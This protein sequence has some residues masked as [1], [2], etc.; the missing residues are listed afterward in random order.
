[1]DTRWHN[2]VRLYINGQSLIP[3]LRQPMTHLNNYVCR[4]F[5]DDANTKRPERRGESSTKRLSLKFVKSSVKS[6]FSPQPQIAS[7]CGIVSRYQTAL[8]HDLAQTWRQLGVLIW[9]V[10]GRVEN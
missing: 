3:S 6:V 2:N 5:S 8:A 7:Y 10:L 4:G 9:S 1:M